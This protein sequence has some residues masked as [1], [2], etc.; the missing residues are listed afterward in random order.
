MRAVIRGYAEDNVK[1]NGEQGLAVRR[2]SWWAQQG[3]N[4]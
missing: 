1:E 4:L 2:E 3:S